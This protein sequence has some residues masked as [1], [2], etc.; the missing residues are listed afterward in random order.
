MLS[1]DLLISKVIKL[2]CMSADAYLR[3]RFQCMKKL[4][5]SMKKLS[6]EYFLMVDHG[7][8]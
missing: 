4:F 7:G 8:S 2:I 5:N 6:S 3:I 1:A